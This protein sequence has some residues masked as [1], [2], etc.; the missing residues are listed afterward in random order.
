VL[1]NR[2][3]CD[4]LELAPRDGFFKGIPLEP[5]EPFIAEGLF[6]PY[7]GFHF[8]FK[9]V[10]AFFANI[11]VSDVEIIPVAYGGCD[12]FVAYVAIQLLHRK[13]LVI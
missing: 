7:D 1:F 3:L 11:A 12:V 10:V 5:V 4:K 8:R 6:G 13:L 2:V 9:L